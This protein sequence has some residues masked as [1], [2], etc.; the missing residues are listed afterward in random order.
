MKITDLTHLVHPDMPVFPGTEQPLFEKGT[1]FE[2]DGFIETKITLYSHT[3]THID[4]PAHLLSDG[5]SLDD[6]PIE[7]FIGKAVILDFSQAEGVGGGFGG[8]R[9]GVDRLK[10]Y[11][12]KI[13][14][15]EFILLKTG[16]EHYWGDAEYF[17]N[18]PFLSEESAEWLSTFT[19]K[20]VGIDAISIDAMNSDSFNVH[21]I[22]LQKNILIIEN[23]CNFASIGE[24]YFILSILPLKN[25]KADGSPVRAI[26]IEGNLD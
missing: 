4:A 2:N 9:I 21:K 18:F 13:G 10:H 12:E 8:T 26:T 16:W 14:N 7:H 5:L 24:E 17:E 6:L 19:L 3:G 23:L 20:G 22:F 11:E 1:T 25:R 15:A